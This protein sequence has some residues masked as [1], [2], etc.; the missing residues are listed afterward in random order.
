MTDALP[1]E[2]SALSTAIRVGQEML[3]IYGTTHCYAD[4]AAVAQALGAIRESLR[5]LL[6]ALG[7]ETDGRPE[8]WTSKTLAQLPDDEAALPEP[9]RELL[10][11][12]SATITLPDPGGA[13]MDL[14][15]YEGTVSERTHLIQIAIRDILDGKAI[16]GLQWEA[17]YLRK[18]ITARPP[19]YRTSEQEL[20][21]LRRIANGGETK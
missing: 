11:A 13:R 14:V 15:R 4:P 19:R 10:A 1:A 2:P 18:Q 17:D 20:A 9:V 3:A 21:D 12:I 16:N 8:G 5:I 6:R 7:A